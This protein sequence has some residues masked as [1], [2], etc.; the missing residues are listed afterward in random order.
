MMM[1]MMMMMMQV[2]YDLV[3]RQETVRVTF[4]KLDRIA[5]LKWEK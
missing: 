5:F 2:L 3:I 1:M 4:F